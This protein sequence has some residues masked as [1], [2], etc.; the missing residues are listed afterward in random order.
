MFMLSTEN[1]VTFI[2]DTIKG[3]QKKMFMLS[4]EN[5]V[6]FITETIKR[7]QNKQVMEESIIKSK[8][9]LN[10]NTGICVCLSELSCGLFLSHEWIVNHFQL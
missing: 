4:T 2:T 5:K 7:K 8:C 10:C 1:K 3:K 6:T 9:V